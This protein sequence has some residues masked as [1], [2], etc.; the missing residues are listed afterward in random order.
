MQLDILF[1]IRLMRFDYVFVYLYFIIM[2]IVS[3]NVNLGFT[4]LI[5]LQTFIYLIR[6]TTW[7]MMMMVVVVALPC[8]YRTCQQ[9]NK[10]QSGFLT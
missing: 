2:I 7:K 1:I 10:Y 5:P 8:T 9:I 3:F 4:S 6:F